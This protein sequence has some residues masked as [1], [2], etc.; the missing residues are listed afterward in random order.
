MIE[1]KEPYGFIYITTNINNGKR[2]IGQKKFIRNWQ[3]Y[4]GSG[5]H[6]LRAVKKY[7]RDNFHRDIVAT[8]YSEGE[9]N[10]LER[11]WIKNYNA[12]ESDDFYNI[13]DGGN[14]ANTYA[15]KTEEEIKEIY[16][17][18]RV[19]SRGINSLLNED[20]VRQIKQDLINLIPIQNIA[21]KYNVD[22]TTIGKIKSC[23]NWSWVSKEFNEKLLTLYDDLKYETN[24]KVITYYENNQNLS[25]FQISQE[26]NLPYARV[27]KLIGD[28][29]KYETNNIL[30]VDQRIDTRRFRSRIHINKK[31]IILGNYEDYDNA[32]KARLMGEIVYLKTKA[33]QIHK[34]KEYD[35]D[36]NSITETTLN[37]FIDRYSHN[38]S[39]KII[40]LTTGKVFNSIQDAEE[41]YD[42]TTISA[43]ISGKNKTAGKLK[44]GTKLVWMEYDKYLTLSQ[45]EI[46]SFINKCHKGDYAK[47]SVICL[48]TMEYFNSITEASLKYFNKIQSHIGAC[49]QGKRNHCGKHPTT[50]DPLKWKY[51]KDLTPEEC[52]KYNIENK[53]NE[54]HNRDLGLAC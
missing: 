13:A 26:L 29:I 3:Y 12:V 10:D 17:K 22:K 18:I 14:C 52:I 28:R 16:D 53:L 50:G 23:V 46:Q 8:A 31:E 5:K 34:L 2:Y 38:T 11:K 45:K 40:C 44:D 6:F 27:I 20:K 33:P 30:G 4:L 32:V 42:V 39:I 49:C 7:G 51:I 48:T 21:K 47:N 35:I 1:I 37:E 41:F 9:L 43:C 19:S 36:I 15:G 54:L 24:N 25:M